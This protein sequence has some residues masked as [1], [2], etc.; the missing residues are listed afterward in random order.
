[1]NWLTDML[2]WLRRGKVARLPYKGKPRSKKNHLRM[3]S[4]TSLSENPQQ[5]I[6]IEH[7]HTFPLVQYRHASHPHPLYLHRLIA[8]RLPG[9]VRCSWCQELI[10]CSLTTTFA[11]LSCDQC[12]FDLCLGCFM[13]NFEPKELI[14]LQYELVDDSSSDEGD[15]DTPD[16]K[17]KTN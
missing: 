3:T 7:L 10:G 4:L 8:A 1:M 5:V 14:I 2:S 6:P 15:I 17:V 11:C 13:S 12:S 9:G 16:S